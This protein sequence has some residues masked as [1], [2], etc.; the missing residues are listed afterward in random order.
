MN[1]AGYA[2][3]LM[4]LGLHRVL[5]H[6]WFCVQYSSSH[7]V[8]YLVGIFFLVILFH[9]IQTE[10]QLK[11]KVIKLEKELEVCKKIKMKCLKCYAIYSYLNIFITLFIV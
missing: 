3:E 7:A 1:I 5:I 10:N 11:T 2:S 6:F 9:F 8:P 4:C